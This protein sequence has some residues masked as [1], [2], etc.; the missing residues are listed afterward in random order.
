[1]VNSER[2]AFVKQCVASIA[3]LA[4][5]FKNIS[6]TKGRISHEFKFRLPALPYAFNALEPYI[7]SATMQIHHSKHHQAYVDKLNTASWSGFE[8]SEH[9]S[10]LCKQIN[11][12]S[13][14]IIRNNLGGHYNHSLF[15]NLLSAQPDVLPAEFSR[16][17]NA[18][19]GSFEAFKTQFSEAALKHF[20]SGWCWLIL[21]ENGR[22]KICTTPN[23]DNPLMGI[24]QVKGKPLLALDL[25]EH[26]YYLK[27]QNRRAEY[28]QNWFSIVKWSTCEALLNGM[29]V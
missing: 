13:P 23:Q 17:L 5:P 8:F 27:Y 15:W 24:A 25:W 3:F 4:F 21:T 11:E 10:A 12:T 20:G 2:R 29:E 6:F 1:M 14:A 18:E 7:D 22:F 16:R 26:A 28:I 9:L 19:F